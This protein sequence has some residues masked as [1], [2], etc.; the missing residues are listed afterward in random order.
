LS[1]GS[2]LPDLFKACT[3]NMDPV[4]IANFDGNQKRNSKLNMDFSCIGDCLVG[5]ANG[6]PVRHE[7]KGVLRVD[8]YIRRRQEVS[9]ATCQ[10]NLAWLIYIF[11]SLHNADGGGLPG[12][13]FGRW[14]RSAGGE[15]ASDEFPGSRGPAQGGRQEPSSSYSAAHEKFR[16]I[17][18]SIVHTTLG[19]DEY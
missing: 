10:L 15:C 8:R 13:Q 7:M 9:R 3:G 6:R 5:S 1:Y 16:S 17:I 19:P 12:T 18:T 4:P 11:G 14:K 2:Y